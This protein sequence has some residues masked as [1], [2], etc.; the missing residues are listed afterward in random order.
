MRR[1]VTA[2]PLQ[3]DYE[4]K[5]RFL[6]DASIFPGSSGSPV[7]ICNSGGYANRGNFNVGTRV[8]FLGVISAVLI[9]RESGSIDFVDIPTTLT[10]TFSSVQMIDLG[11]VFKS[12]LVDQ[13]TIDFLKQSGEI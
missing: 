13:L 9:R 10:P 3:I 5:Q 6:V 2:T 8:Y 1:G 7:F 4:G 12:S 11:V